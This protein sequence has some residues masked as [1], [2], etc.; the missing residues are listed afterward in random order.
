M[1]LGNALLYAFTVV[2]VA[3]V[4]DVLLAIINAIKA[5]YESFDI[6]LLPKFLATGI[7]PYIGGLGILALAA[8]FIGE[9]FSALFYAS[10]AA[11]TAKYVAEIKDKI[12]A[13]L[14]VEI[15]HSDGIGE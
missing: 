3:I 12:Q 14:G 11:A 4:L 10:A 5:D 8:E 9:P 6:R 2:A 7:L 1:L 15:T 13:I